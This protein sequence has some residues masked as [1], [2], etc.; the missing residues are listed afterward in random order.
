M[1]AQALSALDEVLEEIADVFERRAA[2]AYLGEPVTI[3]E[4][5]LQ[6]AALAEEAGC[7][8]AVIAGALLHDIGHFAGDLGTFSME[9]GVDRRHEVT[10]AELLQGV[11]PQ[12]TVACI[13]H[14]VAA[15]RY[16]CATEADYRAGLSDASLH[17][18]KLQG[19]PMSQAE[20]RA[21]EGQQDLDAILAVR[22][23]D[24]SGKRP[25][26]PTRPFRDY[27]PLLRRVATSA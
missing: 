6:T 4:H 11:F 17:S 9:D 16:L 20:C 27:L 13:R 18:L 1:T 14:H 5:M 26:R 7:D 23:F 8:E 3:S 10:G 24:D 15:K 12:R 21:F 25:E 19:G 22:R 2:E